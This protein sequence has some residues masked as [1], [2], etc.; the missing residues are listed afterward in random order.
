MKTVYV[1]VYCMYLYLSILM[2]IR[3]SQVPARSQVNLEVCVMPIR[4]GALALPSISLV[5]DRGI[6]NS[7][8][9]YEAGKNDPHMQNVFVSPL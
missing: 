2:N 3:S 8:A 6:N 9:L 5:W 1:I 7:L 4:C